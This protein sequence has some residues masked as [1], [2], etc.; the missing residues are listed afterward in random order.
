MLEPCL[1]GP[2]DDHSYSTQTETQGLRQGSIAE[3]PFPYPVAEFLHCA[4][5]YTT[6]F[7][8]GRINAISEAHTIIFIVHKRSSITLFT[9][10]H[11]CMLFTEEHK[12][13]LFLEEHVYVVLRQTEQ[14]QGNQGTE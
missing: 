2:V 14:A 5:P 11:R 6:F 9:E 13:M 1:R 7:T 12:C 3:A 8:Y 4:E 10:E